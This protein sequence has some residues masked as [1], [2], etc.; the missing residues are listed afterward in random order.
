MEKP[1]WVGLC[2][3][4]TVGRSLWVGHCGE[5]SVGGGGGQCG[6][7]TVGGALLGEL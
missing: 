2:E 5:A 1:P 6:E 4:P 7:A 3:G